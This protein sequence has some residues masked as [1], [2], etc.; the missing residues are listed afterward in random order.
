ME[1]NAA[2]RV[3]ENAFCWRLVKWMSDISEL[4]IWAT[5][6]LCKVI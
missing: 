6:L 3:V 4:Q 5:Q 1:S 2:L